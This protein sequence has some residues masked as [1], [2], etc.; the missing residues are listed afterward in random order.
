MTYSQNSFSEI[1]QNDA[2]ESFR[3]WQSKTSE[4]IDDYTL[5]KRKAELYALV[6]RIIKDDL[7]A[8]QQQLI[9]LHWYEGKSLNEIAQMLNFDRSVIYRKMNKINDLIYDKLKYAIEY[10]YGKSFCKE[11]P[12]ILRAN[13]WGYAPIDGKNISE[14]IFILRSRNSLTPS[15]VSKATGISTDRL[16]VIEESG[17]Q[18]TVAELKKLVKLYSTT[19]DYIIFGNMLYNEGGVQ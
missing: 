7:N 18:I 12:E 19:S 17:E 10:R 16:S 3:L 13:R 9:R 11:V 2:L 8:E 1:E 6:R 14:R 15:D 4:S 5:R